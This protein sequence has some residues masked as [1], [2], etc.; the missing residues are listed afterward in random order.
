MIYYKYNLCWFNG[1]EEQEADFWLPKG[2]NPKIHVG[3]LLNLVELDADDTGYAY[4]LDKIGEVA[5][6]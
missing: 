5:C 3:A 2:D 4:K 1:E 6:D